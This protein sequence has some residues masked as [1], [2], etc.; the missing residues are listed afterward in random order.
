MN[1]ALV[2]DIAPKENNPR[3]SEGSFLRAPNGDILFAYSQYSGNDWNDHRLFSERMSIPALQKADM[4]VNTEIQM[5]LAPKRG[6]KTV[7]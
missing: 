4:E 7:I 1:T 3:N 6:T 2:C 5:P